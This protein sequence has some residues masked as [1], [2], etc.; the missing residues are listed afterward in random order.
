MFSEEQFIF[1]CH[2]VAPFLSRYNLDKPSPSILD[3][4]VELFNALERIDK[5]VQTL[6]YMDPIC[7]LLYPFYSHL[8]HTKNT[9]TLIEIDINFLN[10]R[11]LRYHIKYQYVGNLMK[12][13]V[14]GIVSRLRLSLQ[15]KLRF[16]TQL[17]LA[18]VEAMNQPSVDPVVVIT[19]DTNNTTPQNNSTTSVPQ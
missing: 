10:R 5:H 2:L 7:D 13:E 18:E 4:T 11:T 6:R 19:N 17:S 16:I 8:S 15:K 14:E 1:L 3:I 9:N 12:S